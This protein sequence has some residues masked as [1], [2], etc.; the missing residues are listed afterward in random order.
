MRVFVGCVNCCQISPCCKWYIATEKEFVP[1]SAKC[2][3]PHS[4]H[5]FLDLF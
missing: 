3:V 2:D 5:I 1:Y 4:H